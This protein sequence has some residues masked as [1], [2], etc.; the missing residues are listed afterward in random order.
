MNTG[1]GSNGLMSDINVTP[2]VD[3]MLVLLI[4]FM[5]TA[6]M[7]M[8]GLDVALPQVTTKALETKEEHL[9]ITVRKDNQIFIND[10]EVSL[11]TLQ[12][13]LAKIIQGRAS[14]DVY[15]KADKDVSYGLVAQVMAR[16][17]D[18]GVDKLGMVTEPAPPEKDAKAAKAKRG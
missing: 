11:D 8:Q 6:P 15:L 7:L 16:I 14:A 9:V 12:D 5:V 3:V 17:K 10:F 18:A 4:I 1:S 2:F 13:K